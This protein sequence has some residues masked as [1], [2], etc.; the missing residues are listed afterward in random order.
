MK[1]PGRFFMRA[2]VTIIA[3]KIADFGSHDTALCWLNSNKSSNFVGNNN[4]NA[5]TNV[6]K[7]IIR[8][9]SGCVY[10]ALIV[11]SVLLLPTMPN[12]YA[13]VFGLFIIIGFYELYH[14]CG[15]LTGAKP[16]KTLWLLDAAG[17]VALM[18]AVGSMAPS[19]RLD[20]AAFLPFL[21]YVMA[22]GVTMLY[23]SKRNSLHD[24]ATSGLAM[25]YVA[26]PLSLLSL[27]AAISSPRMILAMFV[28][29]WVNDSG[30]Y[31]VGSMLGRHK[32]FER[33]SPNKSWEGFWGG[34]AACVAAAY[35][36]F[37]YLNDF[38]SGPS[39]AAWIGLGVVVSVSATFGD[40]M[41]SLFKRTAGVKDSGKLM[42]GHGGILDRID[43]LLLVVPAVLAYFIILTNYFNEI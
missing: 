7:L 36:M 37:S 26:L 12:I 40:L 17:G 5:K 21:G 31:L 25:L 8:L 33:I 18:G 20:A 19:M 10:V 32:L 15:Q 23:M 34:F 42:P 38:F 3:K 43:S 24:A 1:A 30:A 11:V 2:S 4:A 41:E 35:A 6:K 9:L 13:F 27:V 16:S 22:R 14:M 39:A 28:F 29:I